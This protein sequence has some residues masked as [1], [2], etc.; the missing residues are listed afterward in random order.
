MAPAPDPLA[1]LL[2]TDRL[3]AV[4]DIGANPIDGDP[5]Y[6]GMLSKRLCNLV[7][8]EPQSDALEKLQARKSDLE[9]YLPYAMGDGRSGTLKVCHARGMSSLLTP[10]P[11]TLNVFPGFAQFGQVVKE[12]EVET[13]TLDSLS[14][15]QHLDFLKIDVQGGELPIFRNGKT[16]LGKA[17]AVHTEVSFMPLYKDQPPFGSIDLAL[18]E[19][20]FVPHMFAHINKRMI[21][22]LHTEGNPYTSLNQLLE[23]D[24]VYVRDFTRPGDMDPEQLKH[25]ALVAHHCYSSID[26][27][28]NCIY[29]LVERKV[30]PAGS[31][32][33]YLAGLKASA[34]Q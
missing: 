25:L 32:E 15:I 14:E 26:L 20:G 28:A 10:E 7:G 19:L 13:R 12:I 18:R 8:F 9:T 27:A 34:K 11:R 17:V 3:T 4:V 2:R 16:K 6:K 23:A 5:P 22:P 1:E 30:L 29:H 21:L 24:V 33:K 31:V